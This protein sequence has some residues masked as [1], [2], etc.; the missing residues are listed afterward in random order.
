MILL[1]SFPPTPL[2][3]A[4][5]LDGAGMR[6]MPSARALEQCSDIVFPHEKQALVMREASDMHFTIVTA[7]LHLLEPKSLSFSYFSQ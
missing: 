7:P 5:R 6:G 4:A 2:T 1:Y 3:E